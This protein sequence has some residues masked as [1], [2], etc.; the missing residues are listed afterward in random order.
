[1]KKLHTI[2]NDNKEKISALASTFGF[3]NVKILSP[4]SDSF[5]TGTLYLVVEE[6]KEE[7]QYPAALEAMLKD[8]LGCKLEIM[9]SDNIK[10]VYKEEI[11]SNCADISNEIE[12]NRL[13]GNIN[14]IELEEFE[15]VED[16]LFMEAKELGEEIIKEKKTKNVDL[17]EDFNR[18]PSS[19][20]TP[21]ARSPSPLSEADNYNVA[22]VV[23]LEE[24]SSDSASFAT[25]INEGSTMTPPSRKRA[26][27]NVDTLLNNNT[28][29]PRRGFMGSKST[30]KKLPPNIQSLLSML[31]TELNRYPEYTP[32]VRRALDI[33]VE[34]NPRLE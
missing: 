3:C 16:V 11:L 8:E 1:M 19:I 9:V 10:K 24:K 29:K 5:K 7:E 31:L 25:P 17:Q 22:T 34:N 12:I 33:G 18:H 21:P 6:K 2:L 13:F 14:Q 26:D 32:E 15:D 4:F 28:K 30:E 27:V 20:S 23:S